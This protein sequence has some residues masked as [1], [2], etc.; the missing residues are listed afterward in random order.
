M[1]SK[2]SLK[3][4]HS[5]VICLFFGRGILQF[6]QPQDYQ[7]LFSNPHSLFYFPDF[8]ISHLAPLVC[9]FILILCAGWIWL[10]FDKLQLSKTQKN[11]Y[12]LLPTA[13]VFLQCYISYLAAGNLPEQLIEHS[14][15]IALPLLLISYPPIENFKSKWQLSI[16]SVLVALTFIGHGIYAVGWHLVPAN[17]TEMVHLAFGWNEWG[18]K[19]FLFVIGIIDVLAAVGIFIPVLRIPSFYYMVLWGGLTSLARTYCYVGISSWDT[20]F[21]EQIFQTLLR[22]PHTLIPYLLFR[23]YHKAKMGS[24]KKIAIRPNLSDQ[25]TA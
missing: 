10:T 8:Q 1:P 7:L 17:F 11:T 4:L 25:L 18:V 2:R 12:L 24:P 19:T 22:L 9:G 21:S 15:Q 20:L 6:T 16:L 5:S 3:L 13:L 14:L 23:E